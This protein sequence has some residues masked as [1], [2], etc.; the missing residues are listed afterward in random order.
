MKFLF[1]PVYLLIFLDFL[2][3]LRN[4]LSRGNECCDLHICACTS[5]EGD[6]RDYDRFFLVRKTRGNTRFWYGFDCS[7]EAVRAITRE[8]VRRNP[9]L[10]GQLEIHRAP[11]RCNFESIRG[12]MG[13]D[14]GDKLIDSRYEI[15]REYRE[16]HP[17]A[18]LRKL[19]GD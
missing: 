15:C 6:P 16:K 8:Y 19:P 1:R 13:F 17:G 14:E 2:E 4:R 10:I 9:V 11:C 5:G 12:W 7:E 3:K 18:D